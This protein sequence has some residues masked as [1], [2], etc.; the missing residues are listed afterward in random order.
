MQY[1]CKLEFIKCNSSIS[2]LLVIIK[3]NEHVIIIHEHTIK[4]YII[5]NLF[6]DYIN[7]NTNLTIN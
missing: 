2:F 1:F 3:N 5:D 4:L 6:M 7:L